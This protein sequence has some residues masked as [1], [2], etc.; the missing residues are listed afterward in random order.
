MPCTTILVGNKASYNGSTMI[1]RTDDSANGEFTPKKF[2][3]VRPDQQPRV[4]HSVISHVEIPLPDNPMT[5]TCMPNADPVT[6]GIWAAAGVNEK[7]V[8]MTATETITSNVRVLAADPYV[9]YVPAADG[10]PEKAG[11][12]GEED[13]VVIT[14]PYINSARDGVR[15]LGELL[16]KYGTYEPNGIAFSDAN[17]VWYLETVGGH[18]W[19]ARK[20]PDDCYA[21]IANE[22]S[23]DVFDLDDATGAQENFMASA[24]IKEFI[25]K[26]DLNLCFG[27]AFNARLAFGSHTDMDHVYNTPRVWYAQRYFSPASEKWNGPDATFNPQSDNMPWCRK[28]EFRIT[29]EDVKYVLSSTYQG[30][31][32][33]PYS[34]T[35]Q[36]GLY[37][38]IG[39]NRTCDTGLLEVRPNVRPEV[40]A[41]QWFS[42]GSNAY[43]TF[44]PMYTQIQAVPEYFNNTTTRVTTESFYWTNRIIA[45]LSDPIHNSSLGKIRAYQEAAGSAVRGIMDRF[46]SSHTEGYLSNK[47][48]EAAN[49][50][51]ADAI[52]QQTEKFL[53]QMLYDAS[54]NMKNGYSLSDH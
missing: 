37:R 43:N 8:A 32:Y 39:I 15:R 30:T 7:N 35:S 6:K 26:N 12:I 3:V 36:A 4:Y 19:I 16:E 22:F 50:E 40:A 38:P 34:N 51:I 28:P 17:E 20:L 18:H 49:Q 46:E 45:A 5:Y 9:R 24:D 1:C 33:D 23:L 31:P 25:E 10:H 48:L 13:I 53:S 14:L 47:E 11:G 29:V 52:Q 54:M 42:F 44:V 2:S 41:I 27:D 21:V